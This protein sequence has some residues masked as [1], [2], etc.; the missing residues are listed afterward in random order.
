MRWMSVASIPRP[1]MFAIYGR[2]SRMPLPKPNERYDWVQAAAGPALVCRALEA[3]AA[4][5]FT[6]R[7]WPLGTADAGDR[8]AA[9]NDVARALDVDATQLSRLHQVHGASVVVRRRGDPPPGDRPLPAADIIVSNDPSLA[10]AIQ[11]A[12]CVPLLIADRRSG[13]VAA[14]H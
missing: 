5:L 10:L 12:D 8:P 2:Y 13:A 11:S 9:W 6:T 1:M 14:V 7:Q 3:H 4:H